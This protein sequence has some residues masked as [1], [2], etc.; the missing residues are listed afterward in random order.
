MPSTLRIAAILAA[1]LMAVA[2]YSCNPYDLVVHDRFEQA[3]FNSD[4]DIL[5]VVD[6][7][8]SMD[9]IQ[10]EV[11]LHFG[12]FISNFA[13][14]SDE[15]G[16]EYDYETIFDATVAWAEFIKN[17][18]RFLNYNMGV[19]TTD[20]SNSGNG[21]QGNIRSSSNIGAP[22]CGNASVIT[23]QSDNPAGEFIN[24]VDV[25][26]NGAGDEQAVYAAAVAMCKG[27]DASWWSQLDERADTD[28]VKVV[29]NQVPQDQRACNDGFFRTDAATVVIAVSDEGDDTERL[30]F[31]PPPADLSACV[32]AHNDDPF[33]GEC[34]CRV[35]WWLDF[36]D[37]VGQPVVFATIGPTY[38]FESDD[39]ITCDGATVNYP[40]P[41]NPF[42]STTCSVDFHQEMACH[43]GGL[44]TPIEQTGE[45]D[46]PTTC[47][48][49]NFEAALGNIGALVSNLSR[50]WVLS[51]IPDEDTIVV[52]RNDQDVVPRLVDSPSGGWVY[53]PQSRSV[54]FRGEA[55]PTY[56]DVIDIYYLPQHDRTDTVGRP[57]PF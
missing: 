55:L 43:T 13:N 12:S 54:S 39:S 6:N 25:G 33:F 17:Q 47:E 14:I 21:N 2:A 31:L 49:A 15:E 11:Q 8:N 10:E 7:S 40:G 42:G 52:V 48:T 36:F 26:V 34:D 46:D 32:E 20:M 28:P 27:K 44:F 56:E 16:I 4:V 30:E 19:V 41:C 38:Q 5:W 9:R 35:S 18:E 29:C 22:G 50:A 37:G 57:L 24:L 23:P 3:A 1:S 45:L 53:R 51:A